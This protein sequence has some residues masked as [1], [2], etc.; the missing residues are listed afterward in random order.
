MMVRILALCVAALFASG[1]VFSGS[2]RLHAADK[3]KPAEEVSQ[4]DYGDFEELE[5]Q[6]EEDEQVDSPDEEKG[7]L[8]EEQN[9]PDEKYQ[10]DRG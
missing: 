5:R 2:D 7:E 1:V 6:I 9:Y 8:E 10:E 4:E 3:E